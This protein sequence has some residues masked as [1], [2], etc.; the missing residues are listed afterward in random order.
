MPEEESHLGLH[1]SDISS[2]TQLY[3][4]I[5]ELL[6]EELT[7]ELREQKKI[8]TPLTLNCED[9]FFNEESPVY[10]GL[11]EHVATLGFRESRK[12]EAFRALKNVLEDSF[13]E[14][15]CRNS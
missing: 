13:I 2:T 1:L 12:L 7:V 10:K 6:R 4:R 5:Y 14:V 3:S 15:K 9:K 11:M 8:W